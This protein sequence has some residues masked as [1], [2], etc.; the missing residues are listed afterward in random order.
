MKLAGKI[1]NG[2]LCFAAV[3]IVILVFILTLGNKDGEISDL[4][5][6][7]EMLEEYQNSPENFRVEYIKVYNDH[8]FTEDGYFSVSAGRWIPSCQQWQFTVRYNKSTLEYLGEERGITL[9][10]E[11][12]HFTF[13]LADSDGN[14]YSDF[15]YKK[16][17]DG[18]YTYYRLIFDD[19]SI[20]KIDNIHIMIYYSEDAKET[21]GTDDAVGKLPLYYSELEKEYYDFEDEL[22]ENMKPTEG[23]A[24]GGELTH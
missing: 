20:K 5:W 21:I 12:D 16:E 11:K 7:E 8:Y 2:I 10:Q 14:V 22:P 19:V 3:L 4:A 17:I 6:T 9:E 15:R 18:R 1:L 23:F 24:P 13:A